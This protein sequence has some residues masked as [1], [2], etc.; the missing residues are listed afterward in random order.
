MIDASSNIAVNGVTYR[1]NEITL[2]S[3]NSFSG[4]EHGQSICIAITAQGS[5]IPGG[6]ETKWRETGADVWGNGKICDNIT[7]SDVNGH[8]GSFLISLFGSI[9]QPMTGNGLGRICVS[10]VQLEAAPIDG[11][12]IDNGGTGGYA[13]YISDSWIYGNHGND[14]KSK[15]TI[16]MNNICAKGFKNGIYAS[17]SKNIIINNFNIICGEGPFKNISRGDERYLVRQS[18]H[19]RSLTLTNGQFE[20]TETSAEEYNMS[21]TVNK[22]HTACQLVK[23]NDI[24]VDDFVKVDDFIFKS[25]N[26][27]IKAE[28]QSE[29]HLSSTSFIV[30]PKNA[31]NML[32]LKVQKLSEGSLDPV[33]I[34]WG[35]N[36]ENITQIFNEGVVEISHTYDQYS[37]FTVRVTNSRH[38]QII[39]GKELIYGVIRWANNIINAN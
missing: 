14:T 38:M 3:G 33:V 8:N 35:D 32:K 7:V 9:K 23:I 19:N 24:D 1:K 15:A 16:L 31:N 4:G 39:D 27:I 11:R 22:D 5:T 6:D 13:F 26:D 21:F 30:Y 28:R 17:S 37:I 18:P 2:S 29:E 36:P 20:Y 12:P 25:V 10:N 34:S